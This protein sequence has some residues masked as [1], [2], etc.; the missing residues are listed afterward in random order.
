MNY[1]AAVGVEVIALHGP[2]SPLRW[3]PVDENTI[4]L[5]F[6]ATVRLLLA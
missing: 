3:G 2:T 6:K 4:V 5:K 1:G